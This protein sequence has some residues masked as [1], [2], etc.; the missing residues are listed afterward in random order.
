MAEDELWGVRNAFFLGCHQQAIS[1][2]MSVSGSDASR[3]LCNFY[4][5]RAYIEQAQYRLVLDAVGNDAPMALQAVKLLASYHAGARDAKEMALVQLKEWLSSPRASSEPQLLL[6]AALVYATEGELKEALKLVHQSADLETMAL[7]AHIYLAMNRTDLARKQTGLMQQADDDATLTK[8]TNAWVSMAEGGDKCQDALYEFQELGEK[9][10]MSITLTNGM[11]LAQLHMGK[12]DEAER[13]LQEGLGK[14][15]SDHDALANMVVAM[16][17]LRKP[18]D[19]TNRYINQ[20]R[21]IAP[22]HPWISKY[23]E[24]ESSFDRCAAQAAA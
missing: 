1:E 18:T 10:N 24:L 4:M 20:L 12:Y 6:V 2:A 14:S 13:L 8:L 15:A 16:H 7:V 5:Y 21:T 22:T 3:V 11:A 9:Y 23:I 19:V 17:F